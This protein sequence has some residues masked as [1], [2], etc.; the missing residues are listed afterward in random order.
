[1][2]TLLRQDV[3][4]GKH[5]D[6]YV[7]VFAD[8][9]L[10]SCVLQLWTVSVGKRPWLFCILYT[11]LAA[12]CDHQKLLW[13]ASPW[14]KKAILCKAANCE[15]QLPICSFSW[16]GLNSQKHL[17]RLLCHLFTKYFVIYCLIVNVFL[18]YRFDVFSTVHH[19]IELFHQPTLMHN[20]LYSLT[21]CLLH[22]YPRHVSSIN[23]LIFRRTICIHTASG[24][25]ALCKRLH[26]KPVESGLLC[27]LLSTS[28]LCS[29]LKRA[30]IPDALW[31]QMVLLKMSM[32]MLETCRG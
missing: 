3:K 24:I 10:S 25:V 9:V 16:R 14:D 17:Q 11:H 18:L 12:L 7:T 21:I 4:W 23:M 31:I 30:T 28:I 8:L 5:F 26:S 27:S 29:R 22:Y 19:S 32:L 1:M 13:M 20:F 6:K 15:R 2:W